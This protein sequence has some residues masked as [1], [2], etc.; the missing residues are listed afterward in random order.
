[1]LYRYGAFVARRARL[2]L[3]LAALLMVGAA[4][5]G[6]GAFGKLRNGGFE[7]P[8]SPSSRAEQLIESEFGGRL[9]LV[10]MVTPTAG[11]VDD[12]AVRADGVALSEAL[13]AEPYVSEVVS[14]FTTPA[15]ALRSE[16]GTDALVL[17]RV[18]GDE[19]EIRDRADAIIER[20]SGQRGSLTVLAGGEQ[21]VY[22]EVNGAVTRSL[23]IAEGIA[24]PLTLL[25]LVIAF[26]SVVAALLPLAVGGVAILGT[27]AELAVLG[28]V[29]EVSIFSINLTTALGLGLGIDYALFMVN[30]FREQLAAGD[31]VPE[32]V[33]RTVATAGRT[34]IY[35]AVAVMAALAALLVF[36][37]YFLR[38]FG[39]AGIGVVA[40][41]ALGALVLLPALL[42][43]LG[44]RVNAGRVRLPRRLR[45]ATSGDGTGRLTQ[46]A[47]SPFWGRLAG[48]VMRR[49]A[50]IG[51]PVVALLLLAA[52]PLL[53][54]S[55]GSP[56]QDV[57][58]ET[59]ASRQVAAALADRFA[60]HADTPIEIVTTG[61]AG[62]EEVA[63]FARTLSQLPDVAHVSSSAGT[64]VDGFAAPGSADP[65][66]ATPDAQRFTVVTDLAATSDAAQDLVRTIRDLPGPGNTGFLVTGASAAL[67]DTKQSIA[68]RLPLAA[69]LVLL[70]TLIVLFLF[71]G[72]VVQ[73]I[74][75][76]LMNGLS[77]AG[78]LGILTWIFQEGHLASVLGFTP[79]PMD[80]SMTVLLFCIAFGL[81][82]DYEVFVLSRIKELH[83]T[84]LPTAQAVPDGLAR[85]GRIVSTAAG[86]LAV[87]FFAFGTSTVSFLQ[88]FG[89]GAGLAILIDASLVRGVLVPASMR[90]L[91]RAAW[92]S[93]APLRRVHARVALE[94]G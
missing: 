64:Y 61:P 92:W 22:H 71:T 4:V 43:V 91:G 16:G 87:T 14:Y 5:L 26:G 38:S 3:A 12:P 19:M 51:L 69:G 46:G 27:F 66:L 56:D 58:R 29:T 37:L 68:D 28:S 30:R 67:V 75:A 59:T 77:L 48:R 47:P 50:L 33:A 86:L 94:E 17:A 44:H 73:A 49:P 70:T 88:M 85:S 18:E 62:P 24:V 1:M 74:R 81:S 11:T 63:Q 76:I 23:A 93:P 25:L 32:A 35:T 90:L 83:D 52:S 21:G 57:L 79:R 15:P 55:F 2:L 20:Y 42:A 36:P 65:T 13:A 82:M 34:V 40:I 8:A 84:G 41:A 7:D 80:M 78:T 10:L 9:N 45:R 6:A 72:S 54:V 39:Y 31:T 60:G 53:G 89:L